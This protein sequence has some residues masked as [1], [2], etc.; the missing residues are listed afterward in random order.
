MERRTIIT[1]LITTR[2]VISP[3]GGGGGGGGWQEKRYVPYRPILYSL[4]RGLQSDFRIKN[5][6]GKKRGGIGGSTLCPLHI[7][8][9]YMG[10]ALIY[11]SQLKNFTE[12]SHIHNR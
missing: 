2:F 12:I 11:S 7:H 10:V 4:T 6:R 5:I 3:R 1:V 9:I 8:V